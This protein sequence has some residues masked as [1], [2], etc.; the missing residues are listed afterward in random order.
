MLELE[1]AVVDFQLWRVGEAGQAVREGG[2][3]IHEDLGHAA[4]RGVLVLL[5]R[6]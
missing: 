6:C 3:E 1:A 2:E 4:Q 5:E